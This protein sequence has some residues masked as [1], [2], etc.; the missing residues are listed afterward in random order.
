MQFLG[1]HLCSSHVALAKRYCGGVISWGALLFSGFTLAASC[2]L[3]LWEVEKPGEPAWLAWVSH[4]LCLS[5]AV[6]YL[7]CWFSY[8]CLFRPKME[9]LL[10]EQ[11][12]AL[13]RDREEARRH[14]EA[15]RQI[16]QADAHR[17]KEALS[18]RLSLLQ[19]LQSKDPTHALKPHRKE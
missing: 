13:R 11:A 18:L 3:G 19:K 6:S 12:E 10:Q 14:A 7:V 5:G 2:V 16:L 4:P 9:R 17:Q 1:H 8:E 15:L